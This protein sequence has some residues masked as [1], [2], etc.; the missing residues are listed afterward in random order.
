VLELRYLP[1]NEATV[2]TGLL[3]DLDD[4]F[5]DGSRLNS[6]AFASLVRLSEA[7]FR[8][9]A[10]TGRPAAWG[11][12]AARQWPLDGA[13]AENGAVWWWR[14]GKHLRTRD[15][16]GEDR[17]ARKARLDDLVKSLRMAFP[18]LQPSDDVHLRV[19]DYTFDIGEHER[20]PADV[21]ADA[22]R[23]ATRLG[24]RSHTSSVHL[25]VTFDAVDK[26][27]ASVAFLGERFG[28][29]PTLARRGFAYI[30]DSE[31][32]ASCFAA[33]RTSIGVKNLRG[34]PSLPPRY[35]TNGE[36]GTG[37]AEAADRL[38]ALRQP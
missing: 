10:V 9:V 33:F 29:D 7:G 25:H 14:E 20:V 16:A 24:A 26:A 15:T 11:E 32:D 31:N 17:G 38:L 8:L 5:L 27:S 2:L 18:A 34:R 6:D 37:F 1:R 3:F 23:F 35:V 28:V 12:L 36:R 30:G 21:V 4:T 13:I 19:T 22:R